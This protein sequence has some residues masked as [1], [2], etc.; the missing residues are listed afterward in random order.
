MI[1]FKYLKKDEAEKLREKQEEATSQINR[2]SKFDDIKDIENL[3][4]YIVIA[5]NDKVYVDRV[6]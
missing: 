6:D 5:V 1:E 4:K 3:S 2:Y